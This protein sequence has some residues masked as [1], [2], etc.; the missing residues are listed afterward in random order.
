M[1]DFIAG[2]AIEIDKKNPVV[3]VKCHAPVS[4]PHARCFLLGLPKAHSL[5]NTAPPTYCDVNLAVLRLYPGMPA[6]LVLRCYGVG[7]GAAADAEFLGARRRA[8]ETGMLIVA[9]SQCA[10]GSVSLRRYEAGSLLADAGVVSGYVMTT[11]AAFA[12]LHMLLAR[13]LTRGDAEKLMQNN[14]RGELT[15][16]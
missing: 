6:G 7:T 5:I 9:V 16:H 10:E 11:E 15:V 13:G 1:A 3:Q 2:Q 8:G 4:S 14:L 12:K